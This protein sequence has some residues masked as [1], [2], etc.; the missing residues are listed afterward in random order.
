[1]DG[2]ARRFFGLE[3]EHEFFQ[4]G[5]DAFDLD[6]NAL[7]RIVDPARKFQFFG[8]TK[9]KRPK[10]NALYRA[11]NGDLET[12]FGGLRHCRQ[13]VPVETGA[14]CRLGEQAPHNPDSLTR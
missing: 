12:N 11:A 7:R 8:E 6:E 2:T 13:R 1:M 4:R 9:Y 14:R 3:T 5:T 10:S